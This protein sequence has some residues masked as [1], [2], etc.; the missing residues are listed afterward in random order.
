M[1]NNGKR[2]NLKGMFRE[3][4]EWNNFQN[5]NI[6]FS[7]EQGTII[8]DKTYIYIWLESHEQ[9]EEKFHASREESGALAEARV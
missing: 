6:L 3:I 9:A 2:T 8:E 5:L 4:G 1:I 7:Q